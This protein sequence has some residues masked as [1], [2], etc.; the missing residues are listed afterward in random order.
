MPSER[1]YYKKNDIQI[2]KLYNLDEFVKKK[3]R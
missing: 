1:K 3:L 2:S